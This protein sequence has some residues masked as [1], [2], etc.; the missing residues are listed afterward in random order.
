MKFYGVGTRFSGT[1][2]FLEDC[3]KYDF[4]CMGDRDQR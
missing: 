1:E 3:L 4:W 2:S